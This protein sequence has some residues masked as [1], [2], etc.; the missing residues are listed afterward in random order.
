MVKPF[1]HLG[2]YEIVGDLGCGAMGMVFEARDPLIGRSVAI[3][4]LVCHGEAP[5]AGGACE[6][7]FLDEARCAGRLNHPNIVTIYDVGRD[8]V[9]AYIAMEFLK[10]RSLRE[11]LDSGVM[12]DPD[13]IADIASQIG[14]GLAFAHAH[15]VVHC[16]VKPDNIMVLDNGTV[17]IADFG[18]AQLASG[19]LA[20]D[21]TAIGSPKYMSPEQVMGRRLDGRTDIFSLGAVL[22]EMLTGM[23]PFSGDNL[24][25]ILQQVVHADLAAP[26]SRR[27]NLHFGLDAI[28]AKA[29]AK[30][31]EGRYRSAAEMAL[32]LRSYRDV[33]A[34]SS[35]APNP[36]SAI[37]PVTSNAAALRTGGTTRLRPWRIGWVATAVAM[38]LTAT[39]AARVMQ[40]STRPQVSGEAPAP[41]LVSAQAEEAKANNARA[42]SAPLPMAAATASSGRAHR[43]K[44]HG[45]RKE[46]KSLIKTKQ[47]GID[48]QADLRESQQHAIARSQPGAQPGLAGESL[49]ETTLRP[50]TGTSLEKPASPEQL[51]IDRSNFIT[52]GFCENKVCLQVEWKDHA[53]CVRKRDHDSRAI[54]ILASGN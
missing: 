19:P 51:C 10:G 26:S 36:S 43:S 13:R 22:Y 16:D 37:A 11:L 33:A 50:V 48:H 30:N 15:D 4:T 1:T 54:P 40:P 20:D 42:N 45:T 35:Q 52:R 7:R 28:V 8:G 5:D 39:L 23:P 47:R 53:F 46:A 21:G 31:L 9:M 3:K 25:A 12:L 32:D 17:K 29:M 49:V 44:F 41:P 24:G 6:R 38:I 18:V 27:A 14:D 2:R 34:Q